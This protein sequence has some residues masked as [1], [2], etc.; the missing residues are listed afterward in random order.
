MWIYQGVIRALEERVQPMVVPAILEHEAIPGLPGQKPMGMRGRST[1]VVR[2]IESPVDIQKA[3]DVLLHELKGFHRLLSFHGVDPELIVQVFRQIFYFI[4]ASSLNNLLLRKDLCHWSKGM[5]IRYNLSHL[6]QWVRDH[7]MQLGAVGSRPPDAGNNTDKVGE[8]EREHDEPG[9]IRGNCTSLEQWVRDHRMQLGAVGSRPPDAG[10]NS[11]KVGE[12]EREH[13]EP[14]DIRANCTS[15]EQWVRD[16]RMQV[17][18]PTR[19]AS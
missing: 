1:S 14:G 11:D 3:L 16:H 15:L 12:L 5:Q 13:D 9:D 19:W 6:E 18:I 10:N 7:R 2:E 8:L 4:C 17:I